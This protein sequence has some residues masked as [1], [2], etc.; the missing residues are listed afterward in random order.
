MSIKRELREKEEILWIEKRY[1]YMCDGLRRTT[2]PLEI[3]AMEETGEYDFYQ[4][5]YD[6]CWWTI[7]EMENLRKNMQEEGALEGESLW[8]DRLIRVATT[9]DE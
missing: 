8:V 2:L 5:A 3:Q 6:G 4:C 7:G 9:E 1:R